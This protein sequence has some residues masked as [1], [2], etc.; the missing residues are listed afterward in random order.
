LRGIPLGQE[1]GENQIGPPL[2]TNPLLRHCNVQKDRPNCRLQAPTR[3]MNAIY[4][5]A[6]LSISIWTRVSSP[7][8]TVIR[9]AMVFPPTS[10]LRS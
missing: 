6:M 8:R 4:L 10:A 1:K 5:A 9:L 7:A 2:F 3:P